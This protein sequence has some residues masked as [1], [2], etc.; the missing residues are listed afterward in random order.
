M[1]KHVVVEANLVPNL[2]QFTLVGLEIGRYHEMVHPAYLDEYSGWI[3]RGQKDLFSRVSSRLEGVSSSTW[4]ALLYQIPSYLAK[5]SLDSLL[6]TISQLAKEDPR[7]LIERQPEKA[8]LVKQYI[9]MKDFDLYLGFRGRPNKDWSSLLVAYAGIVK[10]IHSRLYQE[11]WPQIRRSLD[12][13]RKELEKKMT[14][15]NWIDWWEQRTGIA[16]PYPLFQVELIDAMRTMGTSLLAE[17]DGFYAHA[18][19]SRIITMISHEICT[20]MLFS[21]EALDNDI[22]GSLIREDLESYLRTVE[23]VSWAT[24]K[25]L[26]DDLGLEWTMERSFDWIGNRKERWRHLLHKVIMTTIGA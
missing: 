23:V 11:R 25:E 19:A 6:D 13:K 26:I 9:P 24:N 16:F 17:R 22:V 7:I 21:A 18:D 14:G 2:L 15:I 3:P 4:F 20:H 8:S 12:S 5:D 1:A 10:N